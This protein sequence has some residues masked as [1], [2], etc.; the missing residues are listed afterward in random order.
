MAKA[1]PPMMIHMIKVPEKKTCDIKKK[2]SAK[3]RYPIFSTIAASLGQEYL[4]NNAENDAAKAI[5]IEAPR[6]EG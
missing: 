5:T 6:M 1:S 3:E 2:L 4:M